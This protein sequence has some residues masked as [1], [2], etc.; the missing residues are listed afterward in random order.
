VFTEILK[1]WLHNGLE[2]SFYYYHDRD[3][4]EIDLLI[5]KDGRVYPIEIKKTAFPHRDMV[6]VFDSLKRLKLQIATGCLICRGEDV[7][8]L[9]ENVYALPVGQMRGLPRL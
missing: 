6:K 3:L 4:K 9:K 7:V 8:P 5:F 1:T 2:P